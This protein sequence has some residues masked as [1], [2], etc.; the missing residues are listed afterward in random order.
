MCGDGVALR[1]EARRAQHISDGVAVSAYASFV[2]YDVSIRL[3]NSPNIPTSSR[4]LVVGSST[5][6]T[7]DHCARR[8]GRIQNNAKILLLH[9]VVVLRVAMIGNTSLVQHRAG[10]VVPKSLNSENKKM[11][12]SRLNRSLLQIIV[13]RVAMKPSDNCT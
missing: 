4:Y 7:V 12:F 8:V 9:Q 10:S 6:S 5:D 13:F 2:S 11:H 1:G 3:Q